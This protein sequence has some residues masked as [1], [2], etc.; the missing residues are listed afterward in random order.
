MSPVTTPLLFTLAIAGLAL[1]QTPEGVVFDNVVVLP[2]HVDN[3]PVMALTTGKALMV[4][5]A[6]CVATQPFPLVT[7]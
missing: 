1:L 5:L 3:V 2:I 6:V 4:T 7:V